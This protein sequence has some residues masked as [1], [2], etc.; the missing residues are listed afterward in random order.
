MTKHDVAH[1][2]I[3]NSLALRNWSVGRMDEPEIE[4]ASTGMAARYRDQRSGL[5]PSY[6]YYDP[7]GSEHV[8]CK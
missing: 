8:P 1:W 2:T 4:H 5:C 6:I 3:S 7:H